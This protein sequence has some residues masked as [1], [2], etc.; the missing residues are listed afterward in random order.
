MKHLSL[1]TA[2]VILGGFLVSCTP[3]E[4]RVRQIVSEELRTLAAIEHMTKGE[5]IGPYSPSVRAGR[6]LF[7]SGQIGVDP[8][9]GAL[10]GT[11]IGA[12]THQAVQ[13]IF[14]LLSQAGLDSSSVVHCSVYLTDIDDYRDMNL[15]YGGYFAEGRYPAR[16]TVAVTSLPAGALV[17][18]SAIAYSDKGRQ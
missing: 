11:T 7:L 4:E 16:T 2:G 6:F 9:T 8:T 17:E 15:A 13:N 5:T 10:A 3:D 18:I 14:S 1:I 12:Q